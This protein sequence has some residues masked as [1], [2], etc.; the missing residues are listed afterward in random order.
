[1]AE[2]SP[3]SSLLCCCCCAEDEPEK[4]PLI[5]DTLR[6][7]DREGKRKRA[8]AANLWNEPQ[9]ASHTE[10]DDDRDLYNLLQRRARTRRGSE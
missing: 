10:R 9:D 3:F 2:R 8:E 7:F 6:Y 1:M 4:S 5:S